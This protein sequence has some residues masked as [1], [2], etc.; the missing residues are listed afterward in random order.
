MPQ[1]H[2]FVSIA[3][4]WAKELSKFKGHDKIVAKETMW[5]FSQVERGRHPDIVLKE[6][7]AKIT[8]KLP[9]KKP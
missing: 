4:E 3:M 6:V 8:E 9:D 7:I 2:K 5:G 1:L